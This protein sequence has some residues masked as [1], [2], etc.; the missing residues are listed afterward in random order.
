MWA[1]DLHDLMLC[2]VMTAHQVSEQNAASAKGAAAEAAE[3]GL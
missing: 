1:V 2:D 3:D